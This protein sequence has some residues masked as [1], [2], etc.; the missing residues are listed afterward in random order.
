VAAGRAGAV[1]APA[2]QVT[3]TCRAQ[4]SKSCYQGK[5]SAFQFGED[6]P[7]TE[8]GTFEVW[9][10]VPTIVCDACYVA[11]MPLTPSGSALTH[12]INPAIQEWRAR[13]G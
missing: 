2:G 11:L 3:I 10:G 7:L 12:E 5:P 4:I 13:H 1:S 8:D 9:D 6:L